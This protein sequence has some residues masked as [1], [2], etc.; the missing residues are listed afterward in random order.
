M[1]SAATGVDEIAVRMKLPRVVQAAP[2][3]AVDSGMG[4]GGRRGAG[5]FFAGYTTFADAAIFAREV[6]VLERQGAQEQQRSRALDSERGRYLQA[7]NIIGAP[8]RPGACSSSPAKPAMPPV[9]AYWNPGMGLVLAADKMP[10]MPPGRTLQLWVV[11]QQGAPIS[12]GI[13]RPNTAGQVL[14]VM[15]PGEGDADGEGAGDQRG[16]RRRK[17]AADFDAG[18]GGAGQLTFSAC[19]GIGTVHVGPAAGKEAGGAQTGMSVLPRTA[20][21][22]EAS[23]CI[24]YSAGSRMSCGRHCGTLWR[25]LLRNIDARDGA[26]VVVLRVRL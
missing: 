18:V 4:L 15:P 13:F 17:S 22:M 16:A 2:E 23:P 7:L 26:G 8:A 20:C 9:A 3:R 21:G 10:E 6:A 14:M 11:P 5:C 12:V 1:P 25:T 24:W 19:S